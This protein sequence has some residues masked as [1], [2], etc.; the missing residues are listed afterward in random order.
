MEEDDPTIIRMASL[1]FGLEQN[2][3][4]TTTML[5]ENSQCLEF[6][7]EHVE[8]LEERLVEANTSL[9]TAHEA[10]KAAE[11]VAEQ[12]IIAMNAM[13]AME[14]G[15]PQEVP[16]EDPTPPPR[17]RLHPR[18]KITRTKKS[19]LAK[20]RRLTH[21]AIAPSAPPAPPAPPTREQHLDDTEEET[22]PEERV[23]ATPEGTASPPSWLCFASTPT[24]QYDGDLSE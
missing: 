24:H 15:D 5:E 1:I 2:L 11:A 9:A 8:T 10:R 21:R 13:L 20:K 12:N 4:I 23:H 6:Y 17:Q 14:N 22:E 3:D 18:I 19:A 7:Q 16:P